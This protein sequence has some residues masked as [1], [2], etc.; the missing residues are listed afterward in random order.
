MNI[1]HNVR[2]SV[3]LIKNCIYLLPNESYSNRYEREKSVEV[4]ELRIEYNQGYFCWE[5]KQADKKSLELE[6]GR[7][8]RKCKG[9][10]ELEQERIMM[11]RQDVK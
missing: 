5:E 1:C 8:A 11:A 7:D 4:A 6:R 10:Q 3:L 9:D 2:H